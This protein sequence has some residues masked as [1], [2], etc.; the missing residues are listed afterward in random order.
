VG[1][2]LIDTEPSDH[3]FRT[4]AINHDC[5][6]TALMVNSTGG[7]QDI[8]IAA[9]HG[10]NIVSSDFNS[11]AVVTYR[12]DTTTGALTEINS[13]AG[14]ISS[15][16]S[17]AVQVKSTPSGTVINV[18]TGQATFAPP[19]AQAA[20]TDLNGSF[21]NQFSGSPATDGDPG[22]SNGIGV[23]VSGGLLLQLN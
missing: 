6:L 16:D 12:L 1:H 22:A 4:F 10:P 17:E 2:I 9:L 19:E 14:A 3:A 8:N 7:E 13:V 11:S 18:F 23:M 21:L 5:S 15:P 20:Q